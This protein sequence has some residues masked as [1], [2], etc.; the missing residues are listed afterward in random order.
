MILDDHKQLLWQAVEYGPDHVK[1][2]VKDYLAD[3]DEKH[4][5]RRNWRNQY[6]IEKATKI[7]EGIKVL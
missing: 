6:M 3:W 2:N 1:N 5:V 7:I 4:Q